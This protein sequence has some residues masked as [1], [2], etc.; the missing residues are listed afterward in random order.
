MSKKDK[1]DRNFTEDGKFAPGNQVH[2]E[3]TNPGRPSKISRFIQEFACVID[4]EH[5]V[6]KAIIFTD[7]ELVFLTN[8]RLD[9]DSE[10]ISE[11]TLNKWKNGFEFSSEKDQEQAEAFRRL[12]R[13]ALLKQREN[14]FAKMMA[15]EE[16][17]SWNRYLAVIERKFDDWN[18]RKK[19]VDET[20]D[21]KKLVFRVA[22][23]SGQD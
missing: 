8:Q 2:R 12:Y 1:N 5:P 21:L 16:S 19:S 14:L 13:E 10:R 4:E 22:D 11:S 20:P 17:R 7:K 23:N 15:P 6:G 9:D 18:L 3:R